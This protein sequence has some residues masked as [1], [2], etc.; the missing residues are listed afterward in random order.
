M[1]TKP[2]H[3]REME[4]VFDADIVQQNLR[5][6]EVYSML[7]FSYIA[8]DIFRRKGDQSTGPNKASVVS[9]PLF[10]LSSSKDEKPPPI[11][12]REGTFNGNENKT[13]R[14]CEFINISNSNNET[15]A[16]KTVIKI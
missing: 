10:D 13:A 1:S 16:F 4:F 3:G 2:S 8:G 14:A 15:L 11:R 6:I 5:F 9:K 7:N 12:R